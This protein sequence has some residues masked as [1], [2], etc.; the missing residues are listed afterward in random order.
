MHEEDD[1]QFLCP[2]SLNREEPLYCN[3][4]YAGTYNQSFIAERRCRA[5]RVVKPD[6]IKYGYC[7]LTE[8]I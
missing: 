8:R 1:N 6:I 4:G 5:W 2:F 3:E 7:K